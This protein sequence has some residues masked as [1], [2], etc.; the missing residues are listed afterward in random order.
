MVHGKGATNVDIYDVDESYFNKSTTISG[1]IIAY[2]GG[3]TG[4][5]KKVI[6]N[7]ES[8]LYKFSFN[9]RNKGGNLFPSHIMCDYKK[10]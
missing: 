2:Y 1:P 5:G 8:S 7:C 10:K 6:V 4:T 9:F 3:T